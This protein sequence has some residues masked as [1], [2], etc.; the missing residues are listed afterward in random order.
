MKALSLL[1]TTLLVCLSSHTLAMENLDSR[2]ENTLNNAEP[3]VI[4]HQSV[5]VE[6]G[7]QNRYKYLI[8]DVRYDQPRAE[9]E[10][11]QS[12]DRICRALLLDRPLLEGLS[13][14]GYQMVAV[15]FDRNYQYDCL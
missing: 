12:V 11:Q 6:A 15:T 2:I 8:V 10:R 9:N 13:D 3:Y 14:S 7:N 4:G 5:W 1:W